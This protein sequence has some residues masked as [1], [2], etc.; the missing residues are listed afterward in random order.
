MQWPVH[1][2]RALD[3]QTRKLLTPFQGLHPKSDG[4]HLYLP[5]KLG[6]HA[7]LSCDDIVH[8]EHCSFFHKA[9]GDGMVDQ[10]YIG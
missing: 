9:G 2:L 10:A 6:G 4:Y 3:G 8:E 1:T 7:L 5:Y